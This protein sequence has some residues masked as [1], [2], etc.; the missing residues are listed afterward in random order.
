MPKISR[1]DLLQFIGAGSVG[2]AGGI[3]Y[4]EGVQREV[5]ILIPQVVPPED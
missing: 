4:G 5:E 1:R 3:L 2:V